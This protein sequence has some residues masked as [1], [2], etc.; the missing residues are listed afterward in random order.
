M[1]I[2]IKCE[3]E[4]K[5]LKGHGLCIRCY[6]SQPHI[7][8]KKRQRENRRY[9]DPAFRATKNS[10]SKQYYSDN[11]EQLKKSQYRRTVASRYDLTVEEYT[12]LMLRPCAICGNP[13]KAMDHDHATGKLREP[14]CLNCNS[15]LGMFKDSPELLRAAAG[16]LIRH[17]LDN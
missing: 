5:T 11:A 2:C 10:Y 9:Q 12:T 4:F 7:L 15:G 1:K 17:K 8:E 16:Y 6:D 3:K 14:L 13:S